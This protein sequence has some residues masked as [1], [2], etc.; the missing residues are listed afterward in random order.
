MEEEIKI[1]DCEATAKTHHAF[2]VQGTRKNT[3]I[4]THEHYYP[5]QKH[6]YGVSSN[7]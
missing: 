2:H 4:S 7:L 6:Q 5:T 3:L 1:P